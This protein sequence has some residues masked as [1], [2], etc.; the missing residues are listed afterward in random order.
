MSAHRA[1]AIRDRKG[2]YGIALRSIVG[3]VGNLSPS[4]VAGLL[5]KLNR[6]DDPTDDFE[7]EPGALGW[8]GLTMQP[9]QRKRS[10][11]IA[12]LFL[13]SSVAQSCFSIL[14][15]R[16]IALVPV[17]K[18]DT[19]SVCRGNR[20]EVFTYVSYS[21]IVVLMVVIPVS[22]GNELRRDTA[23]AVR[24]AMYTRRQKTKKNADSLVGSANEARWRLNGGVEEGRMV[25]VSTGEQAPVHAE[26]AD[27]REQLIRLAIA[28]AA[29]SLRKGATGS[30]GRDD[31]DET[32][33]EA[34]QFAPKWR[35]A[36]LNDKDVS[37]LQERQVFEHLTRLLGGGKCTKPENR[38]GEKLRCVVLQPSTD[39]LETDRFEHG[40]AQGGEPSQPGTG[41]AGS[42][43]SF[44]LAHDERS[45]HRLLRV[46]YVDER[47]NGAEGDGSAEQMVLLHGMRVYVLRA[48]AALRARAGLT[49]CDDVQLHDDETR[50]QGDGDEQFLGGGLDD[51]EGGGV[52]RRG[53]METRT[54]RDK[55]RES[56]AKPWGK[57]KPWITRYF[58]LKDGVLS[59]YEQEAHVNNSLFEKK[60]LRLERVCA[61]VESQSDAFYFEVRTAT[62]H[63]ELRCRGGKHFTGAHSGEHGV[64]VRRKWAMSLRHA[65]AH[66]R[67][68]ID[69][70]VVTVRMVLAKDTN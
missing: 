14:T 51:K 4:T 47:T 62:K 1:Q 42:T 10:L 36:E 58:V 34:A 29:A 8:E 52:E 15:C 18:F 69:D 70:S 31:D 38:R 41:E 28:C 44:G 35:I 48:A 63:I 66:A 37:N 6:K 23:R 11:R 64:T 26:D 30:E 24:N 53:W 13:Y 54:T 59:W 19:N 17:L 25:R 12:L 49:Y 50:E 65:M 43:Y 22:L 16:T 68:S 33:A 21:L 55:D 5:S 39:L 67:A 40:P 32:D 61:V 20:Y 56:A 60:E 9:F 2:I 3:F 7:L 45:A 57:G 46:E 27:I